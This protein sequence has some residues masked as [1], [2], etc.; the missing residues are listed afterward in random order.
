MTRATS[1]INDC[2]KKK[3]TRR[4]AYSSKKVVRRSASCRT[5]DNSLVQWTTTSEC[6]CITFTD[7]DVL[8][9]KCVFYFI[10]I[11]RKQLKDIMREVLN[12]CVSASETIHFFYLALGLFGA[13]A[14]FLRRKPS[15]LV[16]LEEI[17]AMC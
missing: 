11:F 17:S 9:C 15:V 16:A 14:K 6:N 7:N 13:E 1:V 8:N 4:K 12:R 5:G 3:G 2:I 10:F